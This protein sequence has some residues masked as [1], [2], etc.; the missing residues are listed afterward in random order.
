[1]RPDRQIDGRLKD[2][3]YVQ[4]SGVSEPWLYMGP[5]FAGMHQEDGMMESYNVS[6]PVSQLPKTDRI[7]RRAGID[8]M[9][10]CKVSYSTFAS[11]LLEAGWK[12]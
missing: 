12:T 8:F 10:A 2:S 1:M 6:I 5:G 11:I 3:K 7:L 4:M 9:R